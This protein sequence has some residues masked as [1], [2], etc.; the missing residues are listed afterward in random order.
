MFRSLKS[1]SLLVLHFVHIKILKC[2]KGFVTEIAIVDIVVC[3][4][5][6]GANAFPKRR[7]RKCRCKKGYRGNPKTGCTGLSNHRSMFT[8][9]K[10]YTCVFIFISLIFWKEKSI[11]NRSIN[12]DIKSSIF[13]SFFSTLYHHLTFWLSPCS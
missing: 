9:T 12:S 7:G 11:L 10:M 1:K 5:K 4:L 2:I 8:Q 6:C 13:T 3:N